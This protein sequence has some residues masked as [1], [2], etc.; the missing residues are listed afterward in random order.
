MFL[1]AELSPEITCDRQ[2]YTNRLQA[3]FSAHQDVIL[4]G[5]DL[6]LFQLNSEF[7][8]IITTKSSFY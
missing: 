1:R 2:V 4:H 3:E 8:F 5:T 6:R 7:S